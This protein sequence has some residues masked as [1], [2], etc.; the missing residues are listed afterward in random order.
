MSNR[1][2]RVIVN[3]KRVSPVEAEIWVAVIADNADA[4]T[5]LRGRLVGPKCHGVE[6]VQVAFPLRLIGRPP[7]VQP[8]TVIGRVIIPE[9]NMW[10]PETPFVYEGIVELWQDEERVDSAM[11]SVALKRERSA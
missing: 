2:E 9:P 11:L 4:G 6:T 8:N 7:A 10:K 1:I 5:D 3:P